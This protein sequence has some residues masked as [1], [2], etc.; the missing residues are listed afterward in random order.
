MRRVPEEERTDTS[1]LH[2]QYH[3]YDY[4][5]E[6]TSYVDETTGQPKTTTRLKLVK[7]APTPI[8]TFMEYYRKKLQFYIYHRNYIRLTTHTRLE[9][10]GLS[11]GDI[12]LI[13]DDSEKLNKE[14]RKQVR[15]L[16]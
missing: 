11:A 6:Q 15:A 1:A 8:G 16:T 3:F 7:S 12:S 14:R 9:R 2:V 13:M 10:A 4:V 5:E